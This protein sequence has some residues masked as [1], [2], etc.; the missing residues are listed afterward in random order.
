M[1]T[2]SPDELPQLTKD[3][4]LAKSQLDTYGYCLLA[5]AIPANQLEAARTRLMEQAIAEKQQG[6]AF[7][8]GG[9]QQNWGDFRNPDGTLRPEAFTE[10]GGGVNQRVWMLINKGRVF[11][12]LLAHKDVRELASHV[13]GDDYLLSSYSANIAKPGGVAMRL[14]TDQWWMPT[15]TR[16]ARS[17][18]PV[19]SMS[20][21]RFDAD[22]SE[23]SPMI[24]PTVVV[25]VMW[26]LNDFTEENGATR[27]VPGSHK[28]GRNPDASRDGD[29]QS[30][31]G[32]GPAGTVMLF[33]G[34]IWHGTGANT[35]NVSR[36]G[37]LTTFCGPQFRPQENFTLGTTPRVLEEASPDL[38]ALLGFKVWNGYGRIADPTEEFIKPDRHLTEELYPT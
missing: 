21:E 9:K 33:D 29:I 1:K 32:T 7:E 18:L 24:A 6:L 16:R 36:F 23:D 15:P 13:L 12:E 20:R 27:I 28:I 34:R 17:P 5:N 25:N 38:L 35:S 30:I 2:F 10:M 22:A 11:R 26:M 4:V 3:L 31:A 14:H 37:L 8:D 19:G